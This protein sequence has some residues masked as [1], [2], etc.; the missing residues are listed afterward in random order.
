ME[1]NIVVRVIENLIGTDKIEYISG[2][3]EKISM[4]DCVLSESRGCVYGIAVELKDDN[5][6][7]EIF[8]RLHNKNNSISCNETAIEDW[9]SI[10]DNF[11]PLYWGKDTDMGHRLSAHIKT[12]KG[13]GAL[14]LNNEKWSILKDNLVIYGAVPCLKDADNEKK[15]KEKYPDILKTSKD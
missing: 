9:V 7:K 14:H 13:N 5:Q 2:K 15:L 3:I 12:N 8:D 6:K 10:G 1:K 4:K 11:Y